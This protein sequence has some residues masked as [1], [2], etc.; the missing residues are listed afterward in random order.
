[1][2]VMRFEM[3]KHVLIFCG[4]RIKKEIYSFSMALHYLIIK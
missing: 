3:R 1:M 4:F 2:G